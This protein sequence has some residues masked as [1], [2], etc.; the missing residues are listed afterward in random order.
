MG[1]TISLF[2]KWCICHGV[3]NI[4]VSFCLNVDMVAIPDFQAHGME[5]WGLITYSEPILLCDNDTNLD[6]KKP[7]VNTIAHELAHMVKNKYSK[8]I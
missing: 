4:N 2:M 7:M 3:A 1:M 6:I 8:N 5:N